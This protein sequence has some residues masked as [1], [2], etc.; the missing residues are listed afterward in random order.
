METIL[1]FILIKVYLTISK[2]N[3]LI[4]TTNTLTNL[5]R[6]EKS[7][8]KGNKNKINNIEITELKSGETYKYFEQDE[9]LGCKGELK[10]QRVMKKCLKRVRKIWNS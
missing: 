10:K 3:F 9:E 6:K 5:Y 7:Q 1:I 8:E 2:T 4:F